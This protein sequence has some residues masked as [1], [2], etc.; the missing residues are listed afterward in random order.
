M[1]RFGAWPAI[2][3]RPAGP[4][5]PAPGSSPPGQ[6]VR[7]RDPLPAQPAPFAAGDRLNPWIVPAALALAAVIVL[8][9]LGLALSLGGEDAGD[10]PASPVPSVEV[11]SVEVGDEGQTPPRYFTGSAR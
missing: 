3:L 10:E 4:P 11:P 1:R 6:P 2:R 9:V 5:R 7:L 8:I